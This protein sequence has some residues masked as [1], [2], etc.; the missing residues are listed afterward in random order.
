MSEQGG[1]SHSKIAEDHLAAM[2][3]EASKRAAHGAIIEIEKMVEEKVQKVREEIR[4][5][6][7]TF[8]G[9]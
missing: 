7:L 1:P 6:S 5:G 8:E 2:F 3:N 4:T 9:R